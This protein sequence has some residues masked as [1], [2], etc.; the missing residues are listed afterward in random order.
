MNKITNSWETSDRQDPRAVKTQNQRFMNN[1][2][3]LLEK[4][5]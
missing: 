5:F 3:L 4:K 2:I 1:S